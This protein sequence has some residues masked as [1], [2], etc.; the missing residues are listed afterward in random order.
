MAYV[1]LSR[2][3]PIDGLIVSN[4]TISRPESLRSPYASETGGLSGEPLNAIANEMVR[5]MYALTSGRV[6]IIG[7][8]GIRSGR[9]A[10]D[11]IRAGASAV[12]LYTGLTYEGPGI[13]VRVKKQLSEL[14]RHNGF[15]SVKDAV[16]ADHRVAPS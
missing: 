7:V 5:E 9:D 8:G 1:V 13:A 10:Y 3:C 16:G 12:Q 15:H 2:D 11:R 14:L 4:T 6:P